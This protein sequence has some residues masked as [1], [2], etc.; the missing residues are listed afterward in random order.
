MLI[1]EFQT[2]L[3]SVADDGTEFNIGMIYRVKGNWT[4]FGGRN[5]AVP[6][7]DAL[8]GAD[9]ED[10]TNGAAAFCVITYKSAFKSHRQFCKNRSIGKSAFFSSKSGFADLIGSVA[11]G[12]NTKIIT[13]NSMCSIGNTYSK[14]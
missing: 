13:F 5:S 1:F 8:V 10:F 7:E 11:A 14:K 9:I 4:E 3:E 2:V 12:N 6:V